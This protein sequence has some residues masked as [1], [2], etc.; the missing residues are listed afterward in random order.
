MLQRPSYTLAGID[1]GSKL[2]GTTV[3]AVLAPGD[4]V[5]FFASEKGKDADTFLVRNLSQL[6]PRRVFI[7][8]PL[9]L[10][11]VYRQLSGFNDYFY[12]LAD[13]QLQAM[14]PMFLGGLTARAIRLKEKALPDKMLLL[15]TYPAGLVR[16]CLPEMSGYRKKSEEPEHFST[17]IAEKF[18][19]TLL[20]GS[21][22]SWHHVD[23]LLAL[24]S[25]MRFENQQHLLF[26]DLQEGE[27][28]I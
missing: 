25:G 7:D 20:R 19:L 6:Q 13:R 9:S 26:G 17:I 1:Y 15:E 22:S 28:V 14:S 16:Y 3:L 2:A 23:A 4:C 11:G 24:V 21:V 10:P 5:K 27:I 12:R 18:S 8:A